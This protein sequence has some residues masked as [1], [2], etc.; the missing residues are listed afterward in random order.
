L[1]KA[2]P[3]AIPKQGGITPGTK[4]IQSSGATSGI[5][6]SLAFTPVQGIELTN[7]DLIKQQ[8]QKHQSKYFSM[9]SF[10]SSNTTK[11]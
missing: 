5:S 6:S 2:K 11:K 1:K 10:A 3:N 8:Q 7:P 4:T 9:S